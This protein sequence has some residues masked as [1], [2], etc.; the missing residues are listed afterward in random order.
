MERRK[1]GLSVSCSLKASLPLSDAGLMNPQAAG[2]RQ[3]S[4]PGR[5][6]KSQSSV[7]SLLSGQCLL[8]AL[9][10]KLPQK[11]PQGSVPIVLQQVRD[12]VV[13]R[14]NARS[15]AHA[16]I[17]VYLCHPHRSLCIIISPFLAVF[18]RRN[19]HP[20]QFT[21]LKRMTQWLSVYLQNYAATFECNTF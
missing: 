1:K 10:H 3:W 13:P 6:Q 16:D 20:T 11:V 4:G 12:R 7:I 5:C 18:P 15:L 9:C 8:V 21:H 14:P 2:P 19:S 17:S